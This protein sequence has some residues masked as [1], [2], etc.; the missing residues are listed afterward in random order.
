MQYTG[1]LE[2]ETGLTLQDPTMEIVSINYDWTNDNVTVEVHFSEGIYK[3][4]R[5][6]SFTNEGG[7]ELTTTDVM[8]FVSSHTLLGQFS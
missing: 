3:H 2:I 8:Q 1:N 6:Y 4:S 5:S 7:Q